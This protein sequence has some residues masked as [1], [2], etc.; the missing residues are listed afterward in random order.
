[1]S[2]LYLF[3]FEADDITDAFDELIRLLDAFF[4]LPLLLDISFE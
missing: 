3:S 4:E 1:M 2:V